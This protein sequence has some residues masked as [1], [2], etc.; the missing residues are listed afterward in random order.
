MS[1]SFRKLSASLRRTLRIN[2]TIYLPE[3]TQGL[4]FDYKSTE[5][6]FKIIAA[7]FVVEMCSFMECLTNYSAFPGFRDAVDHF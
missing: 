7:H 1:I 3:N 4:L 5:K 2:R 6:E